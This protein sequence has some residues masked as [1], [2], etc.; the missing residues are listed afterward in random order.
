VSWYP[1]G[2]E[3]FDRARREHKLVL[4]SVGYSTCHWCHVM[5]AES[6][7]DPEVAAY[8]NASFICIKV[9]REERPDVDAV[10]MTALLA[11]KSSGGWPMNMVT[12]AER[13]PV[14]GA[15]YLTKPQLLGVMQ[16]LRSLAETDPARL[17]D[18]ARQVMGALARDATASKGGVAGPE[19]IERGARSLARVFDTEAGGFGKSTKF[20]SPPDLE[21]LLRYHRRTSDADALAMVTYTLEQIANGGIHDQLAGGFHRYATDRHWLVPHFEKMLY[22]NAQLAVVYLEAAQVT[23]QLELATI[24]RTTLDYALRE[25]RSPDGAFYSATDADSKAPDGRLSEGYYFTWTPSEIDAVLGPELGAQARAAYGVGG[26]AQ[27]DGR[28]VLYLPGKRAPADDIRAPLLAAREK[29]TSPARDDKVL[30]A[31]NALMI[32]ALAKAGFA[33]HDAGYLRAAKL[34]ANVVLLRL[35][36]PDAGLYRSYRAGE[37]RQRATLEDYAYLVAALLDVFAATTEQHYLDEAIRLARETDARFTDTGGAFAATDAGGE[38]LLVRTVPTDD[39]VLPSGNAVA[40]DNLLRLAEL[41]GDAA[42]RGRADRALAALAPELATESRTPALR[43]V[44]DRALDTPLEIVIVAPHD[45]AEA[46]PLVAEV[47]SAFLPHASIVIGT[48]A[49]L[50]QLA[51][52]VPFVED[53]IAQGGLP[54]AYVCERTICKLPTTKPAELS[55]LLAK[56]TPLLPDRSPA[57]LR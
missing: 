44:L 30:T 29:R 38:R 32:S 50:A 11:M 43:A 4:L 18:T 37:A 35:T 25:M 17:D 33:F 56:V 42:Y 45:V 19:A 34:A 13:R 49:E 26:N 2:D 14:F 23:G 36:A 7:D 41:T 40:I 12:D 27:V 48:Q 24:A 8:L 9:D 39:G 53:K 57:P 47:R 21:L 10:Y 1:W 52:R 55:A 46:E 6:F 28:S 16:Q 3:A 15:T 22:D 54:T 31:W 51:A 20:P 5:E